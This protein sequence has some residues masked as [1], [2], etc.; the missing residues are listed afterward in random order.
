MCRLRPNPHRQPK[1]AL[2]TEVPKRS[3]QDTSPSR[4]D[5]APQVRNRTR[6]HTG[7][8]SRRRGSQAMKAACLKKH[9]SR[10]SQ[11]LPEAS[12]ILSDNRKTY[13]PASCD[14]L[15]DNRLS[16]NRGRTACRRRKIKMIHE[17]ICMS[18]SRIA[19]AHITQGTYIVTVERTADS[20]CRAGKQRH[21]SECGTQ[22]A[23]CFDSYIHYRRV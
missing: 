6:S 10:S 5:V 4:E 14:G 18:E 17:R 7:P 21:R 9:L 1:N 19:A 16:L 12:P 22:C 3:D 2:A 23:G 20:E 13:T 11:E 8:P 15:S